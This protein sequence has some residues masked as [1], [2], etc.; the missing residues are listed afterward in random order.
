M[1][2]KITR[3]PDQDTTDLQKALD[4][5]LTLDP[6]VSRTFVLGGLGGSVSH[7]FANINSLLLYEKQEIVLIGRENVAALIRPGKTFVKTSYS[8]LPTDKKMNCSLIPISGPA[9]HVTTTGL[10]WN[11]DDSS[12]AFGGLVSTSNEIVSAEVAITTDKALLW[13]IDLAN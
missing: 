8:G 10:R 9:D 3:I 11:L 5:V 4:L 1:G 13:I 6:S 12:L 2:V 7:T